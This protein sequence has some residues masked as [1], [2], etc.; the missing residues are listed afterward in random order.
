MS[1]F[2]FWLSH[3]S[4]KCLIFSDTFLAF[5]TKKAEFSRINQIFK[6]L[7][8]WSYRFGLVYFEYIIIMYCFSLRI[9]FLKCS[10]LTYN[11]KYFRVSL[12]RN[13]FKLCNPNDFTS[14]HH[15]Y[16]QLIQ[17][18]KDKS[19]CHIIPV[20]SSFYQLDQRWL[21]FL[22]DGDLAIECTIFLELSLMS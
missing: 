19:G 17:K 11:W 16:Y 15:F 3:L 12:G 2:R 5:F 10:R 18:K 20:H 4:P 22:V 8:S 1:Q 13:C 21:T 7:C 6:I 14:F 9:N